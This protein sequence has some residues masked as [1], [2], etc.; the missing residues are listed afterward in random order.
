MVK[1]FKPKLNISPAPYIRDSLTL[2]KMMWVT[3]MALVFPIVGSIY[4]FG[5]NALY[6][7]LACTISALLFEL[8]CQFIRR[9]KITL[10]GSAVVTGILLALILP[11]SFP[12]W[13]AVIGS[14]F[15]ICV[16]KHIFG[17]LGKNIF[18][19]A[20][21]GRAFLTAAFPVLITTYAIN[22]RP[23]PG[24]MSAAVR[25]KTVEAT[26]EATPLSKIRFEGERFTAG[27]SRQLLYY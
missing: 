24:G 9:I 7:L 1:S 19:P 27:G 18:N 10:D 15:A 8:F 22:Y 2:P 3:V 13:A 23:L 17:G 12:L 14:C 16:V 25:Q 6:L 20:L 5:L 11:P 4:F 26:T 21:M